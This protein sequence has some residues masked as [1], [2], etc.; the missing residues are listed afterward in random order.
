M[1]AFFQI[2]PDSFFMALTAFHRVHLGMGDFLGPEMTGNAVQVFM[3]RA[4]VLSE[5]NKE[6]D[7]SPFLIHLFQSFIPM[8]A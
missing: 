4:F 2:L 6:R 1:N 3:S 5:V 7:L 8:A